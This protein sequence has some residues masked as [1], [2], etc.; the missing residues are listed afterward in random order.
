MQ[1]HELFL[2]VARLK[3]TLTYSLSQSVVVSCNVSET[4]LPLNHMSQ[5]L[6]G[7]LTDSLTLSRIEKRFSH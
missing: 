5:R 1:L 6:K 3:N 2:I 7:G 4:A